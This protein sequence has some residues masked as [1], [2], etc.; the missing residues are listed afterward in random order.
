MRPRNMT[1]EA[2]SANQSD[3]ASKWWAGTSR[4]SALRRCD[5]QSRV[6]VPR[7]WAGTS[8]IPILKHL[9]VAWTPRCGA[10][11]QRSVSSGGAT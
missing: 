10:R 9:G 2:S 1:R 11:A 4:L 7:R 8:R 6:P 3:G 5:V